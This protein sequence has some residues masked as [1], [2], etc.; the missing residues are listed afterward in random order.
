[1]PQLGRCTDETCT[2]ETKQLYECHCCIR[3]ICL[4]HLIEHDEKATVNKQQLQTCIIQLTSVLSTFEMIIEE[5]MRVIEQHKTL[6]EKGKAALATASSANEMQNILDQVQTTIAANQNNEVIVKVESALM[7]NYSVVA[8]NNSC[9]YLS[10]DSTCENCEKTFLDESTQCNAQQELHRPINNTKDETNDEMKHIPNSTVINYRG[11]CPLTFDGAFGL[12]KAKHLIRLCNSQTISQRIL[13]SHFV[14]IHSI[15][16]N[17]AKR[18]IKAI[19]QGQDPKITKLFSDD[20]DIFNKND[21]LVCPFYDS[22]TNPFRCHPK[23]IPNIPCYFRWTNFQYFISHLITAHH[24]T[25]TAIKKIVDGYKSD[26]TT[27]I[28]G[29]DEK[30]VQKH[31]LKT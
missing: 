15:E 10:I 7:E 4:P 26:P 16:A 1:M 3:F 23:Q 8:K 28:F 14:H 20:E 13:Y 21:K 31:Y 6:L 29:K 18:L 5:H 12:T 17:Y 22:T 11:L 9:Q 2:N 24:L 19:Q 30:I 25:K 27:I